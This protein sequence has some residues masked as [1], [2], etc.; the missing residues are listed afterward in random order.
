MSVMDFYSLT[1]PQFSKIFEGFVLREFEI[2]NI[3]NRKVYEMIFNGFNAL[4]G[5]TAKEGSEL[6]PM[7]LDKMFKKAPRE[8]PKSEDLVQKDK[9]FI[10]S[11]WPD[12]EI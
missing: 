6:W 7:T 3:G 1:I 4:G 2:R 8:I 10:K 5:G 12:V 9:E 11:I